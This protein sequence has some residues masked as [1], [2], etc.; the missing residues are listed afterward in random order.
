MRNKTTYS[1]LRH[2]IGVT[3]Q[4]GNFTFGHVVVDTNI[5]LTEGEFVLSNIEQGKKREFE[6]D[7]A[8][9]IGNSLITTKF[10]VKRA[11]R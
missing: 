9:N 5:S 7:S 6:T 3:L 8:E 10:S 11:F 4:N 1:S 2:E